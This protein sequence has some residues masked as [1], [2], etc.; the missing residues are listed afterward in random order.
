MTKFKQMINP[1]QHSDSS[2]DGA[3]TIEQIVNKSKELGATHVA[4]TEHGN[5]NSAMDLY[6]TCKK[7]GMKPILGIELYVE[8]P[9]H[10]VLRERLEAETPQMSDAKDIQKRADKIE[11]KLR[12]SYVH[13]TVHFKDEWAYT[14]FCSL[15]PKMEE[16][17]IVRW[18]E[19][20]PVATLNEVY[21]AQG[22][23]TI[24][25]SCLVG[26]VQKWVLPYK[27]TNRPDLAEKAYCMIRGIAGKDNFFVEIFPH[28]VTHNWERPK[29][30]DNGNIIRQGEFVPIGCNA[31]SP[32]GDIQKLGNQFVLEMSRKYGDPCLISLDAHFARKEQKVIQDAKLGNGKENWRFFNSYHILSTDDTVAEL[33]HTLGVADRDIEEWVD[34]SYRFASLFD[35]FKLSTNKDR[36]VLEKVEAD[37]MI[38]LKHA[39]DRHGRMN[40]GNQQMVERLRYEI[41]ILAFNEKINLMSYMF[42]VEDMADYCRKNKILMNVRGSAAGSLL[43]YLIG[44]SAVNPLE[45]DLSFERFLTLGRIKANTLPD[46]DIDVSSEGRERLISYLEDKYGDRICRLSIDTQLKLRSS[47][48]D[49]ERAI[50]GKVRPETEA[51]CKTLP[52]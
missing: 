18:A 10:D 38:R 42:T 3:S 13:L 39:I 29:Q 12:E 43:L 11:K 40:W 34:N 4:M 7:K 26:M 27:D 22:H 48:K 50:L 19:R 46:V 6:H 23:I 45:Y 30:D 33:K 8:S 2:L 51:L 15:T 25:S 1:H 37:F 17:A 28:Q 20:K 49:A 41:D 31:V 24:C 5:M 47:L 35:N 36:W 9:F 21:G 32:D 16:R 44:V 52:M 14:Y